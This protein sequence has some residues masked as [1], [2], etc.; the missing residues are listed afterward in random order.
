MSWLKLIAVALLLLGLLI[1][2]LT[3]EVWAA[4]FLG[5]L[6][7][8][9]LTGFAEGIR[10]KWHMPAWTAMLLSILVVLVALTGLGFIIGPPLVTQA[11]EMG[12]KLPAAVEQSL[13]W[14]EER[15]WGRKAV[16]YAESLTGM[17]AQP[18]QRE[19]VLEGGRLGLNQGF[20]ADAAV[21]QT[22]QRED[23]ADQDGGGTGID[24]DQGNGGRTEEARSIIFSILQTTIAM[25]SV[26]AWTS[27]LLLISFV[28][29]LYVAFNPQVYRRGL[30]WLIPAEHETAA[31]TTLHRMCVALRWW[32]LGRIC[33]MLVIGLLTSLGMW[34]IGMPAPLALGAL[35]GVLSFVPNIGPIIASVPGLLLAI[36]DGPWMLLS[37]LGVYVGTQ[38][39]E[40]NLIT[41]LIDQ[42][43][44][45][46]PPAM[47]I[48]VQVLMGVLAG[49]W[50][51]LVATPLLVVVMVLTQ[52]LYVRQYLKKPITV[53]GSDEDPPADGPTHDP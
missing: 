47:L 2:W 38:I 17:T 7:A 24:D 14:L 20:A 3:F 44:V 11:D 23:H 49:A 30:L 4:A 39:I 6:F 43:T 32:M 31:T 29:T 9:S 40:S 42:Y 15:K 48:L 41:P 10:A 13:G 52:Q 1:V 26:T 34:L 21:P 19:G 22:N 35:A 51:V 16:R 36:P 18:D 46:T 53:I 12:R 45:T 28:V 33:S 25:L 27:V 5:L 37:V 50:G 8:L